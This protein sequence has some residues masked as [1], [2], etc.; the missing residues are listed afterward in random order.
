MDFIT[1]ATTAIMP[2]FQHPFFKIG[3]YLTA[4]ITI[5]V[6][7]FFFIRSRK[8]SR[9]ALK[10][11]EII[12]ESHPWTTAISIVFF[13][14]LSFGIL[15]DITDWNRP[16]QITVL[17]NGNVIT[18]PKV[19]LAFGKKTTTVYERTQT[20]TPLK[21][22]GKEEKVRVNFGDYGSAEADYEFKMNLPDN[23][24]Q[25]K[26][27]HRTYGSQ[28][29]LVSA[30]VKPFIAE[31]LKISALLLKI[32][33]SPSDKEKKMLELVKDQLNKGLYVVD[34]GKIKIDR[35]GNAIRKK[36]PIMEY[37]V[38][39]SDFKIDSFEYE[40]LLEKLTR[41]KEKIIHVLE[42]VNGIDISGLPSLDN[43][44]KEIEKQIEASKDLSGNQK[45]LITESINSFKQII[46]KL[47]D[48]NRKKDKPG[49]KKKD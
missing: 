30:G 35:S 31:A 10:K 6:L 28:E 16:G 13:L 24:E 2:I 9:E 1:R 5:M 33:E 29:K 27:I 38:K 42:G 7:G 25:I 11:K 22:P 26:K 12:A 36:V 20:Y 21:T 19:F 23:P 4:I 41:E 18:K 3:C 49:E 37:Q 17:E 44:Q 34:A 14:S 8:K 48:K 45:K 46:I 40:E 43:I 15:A 47:K 39:L 32:D